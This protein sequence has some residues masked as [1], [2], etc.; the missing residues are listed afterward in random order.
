MNF[1][2]TVFKKCFLYYTG[3]FIAVF[4]HICKASA[5]INISDGFYNT[6]VIVSSLLF[7][8][9]FL[10]DKHSPRMIFIVSVCIVLLCIL[11]Y[12]GAPAFIVLFFLS[13][14]SISGVNRRRIIQIDLLTKIVFFL[15]HALLYLL[16]SATGSINSVLLANDTLANSM[17]NSLY[18]INPNN[19][20]MIGMWAIIDYLLLSSKKKT[21]KAY[22]LP[23]I[24]AI[25]IFLITTSRTAIGIYALFILLRFVKDRKK[26]NIASKLIYPLCMAI[27]LIIVA[28]LTYDNPTVIE[29]DKA[30]SGRIWYSLMSY[31]AMGVHLLPYSQGLEYLQLYIIDNFYVKC[32]VYY[33]LITV[34]MYL[35]P[36]LLLSKKSKKDTL[37]LSIVSAISMVFENTTANIGL[38]IPY[39][40]MA[41]EIVNKDKG[42]NEKNL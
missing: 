17:E 9:K 22:I 30:L 39:V 35:I 11:Y 13:S 1:I 32:A 41:D 23:T 26:L 38:A 16:D 37:R 42:N 31:N 34:V 12:L 3:F 4:V 5:L 40:I 33:G 2:N 18:F 36:Y 20:G 14:I 29:I 25:V 6:A 19:T 7:L 8:I 28:C 10:L 21:I 27:S 24:A 15:S